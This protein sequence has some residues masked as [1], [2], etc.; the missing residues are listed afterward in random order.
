MSESAERVSYGRRLTQMAAERPDDVELTL[1]RRDGTLEPL[2]IAVLEQ[3]SNQIARLLEQSGV[4]ID[5]IVGLAL[6]TCAEHILVTLAI[7]KLGATLL[8]LRSDI[9][10]WE[11]QRMLA[12][13]QPTVLVSDTHTAECP[14]ITRGD[15]ANATSLADGPLADRISKCVNLIASSGSTGTP[16]LI[17][18]PAAGVVADDAMSVS[19]RGAATQ[20]SLVTSPLYHVNGFLFA[21]PTMLEGGR[22]YVMEKFD[23]AQAVELIER[24]NV[25]FTVMVPTMLQRIARLPDLTPAK[26]QSLKRVIYGGAKAPEWVIDRW[27]ELIEPSALLLNYGSSERIG[28]ISMTGA[29]WA[30]HRGATG[31]AVDCDLSIRGD[32]GKEVALGEVGEIFM[33]PFPG[34]RIFEYV[35]APTPPPTPDGYYSC[36]DLGSV[37]AEGYLYIA[38]RRTDL[39][40]T[41]GANVFPAEVETALSE[42]PS[43]ADQVVVGVPDDEWGHRVHAVIQLDPNAPA[44]DADDLKLFCRERL[45]TYKVPKTFEFVERLPRTEAGKLNRTVLGQQRRA[46]TVDPTGNGARSS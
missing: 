4:D 41:G 9:P 13:A 30:D 46:S 2:T 35:G 11:M 7:W 31:R 29:E 34:R 43:V 21:A 39:I 20:V 28:L 8:P 14:V 6:P 38:D 24:H 42:H 1:V 19:V 26:V 25:T 44:P 12:L 45:A 23:A 18:T 17:M 5:D 22:V 33:R 16:K 32:D 10:D 40:I 3:R 37:D 15:I 36:G 27:L